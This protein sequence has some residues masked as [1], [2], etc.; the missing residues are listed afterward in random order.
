MNQLFSARGNAAVRHP[1]V[2]PSSAAKPRVIR[3]APAANDT[4][5][6]RAQR[7]RMRLQGLV[8]AVA[9]VRLEPAMR[10]PFDAQMRAD[11]AAAA[12]RRVTSADVLDDVVEGLSPA[13]V[14][15]IVARS[16]TGFGPLALRYTIDLAIELDTRYAARLAH[17]HRRAVSSAVCTDGF[18]AMCAQRSALATRLDEALSPAAPERAA[19]ERMA[20]MPKSNLDETLASIDGLLEVAEALLV[21]A[22]ADATL[23]AFLDD[24]QFTRA[25]L[26]A[27]VAPVEPVLAARDARRDAADEAQVEQLSIDVLEGRLRDQLLRV[28]RCVERARASGVKVTP[29][30]LRRI[31]LT[32]ATAKQDA[33]PEPA[34]TP[35]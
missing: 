23:R 9:T 22:D 14:R 16:I 11:D 32:G 26:G 2:S 24:Q 6:N 28:R 33:E 20:A 7:R 18:D 17:Q 5:G 1:D 19:Y 25:Q 29:V 15:A 35:A 27:L 3:P 8:E 34:P 4:F 13:V 21:R 30:K 10:A 31:R 12:G